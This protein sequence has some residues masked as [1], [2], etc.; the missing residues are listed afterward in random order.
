MLF[1]V[2]NEIDEFA[3][4]TF[5]GGLLLGLGKTSETRAAIARREPVIFQ[6]ECIADSCVVLCDVLVWNSR[7]NVYDLIEVKSSTSSSTRRD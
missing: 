4:Q 3:R 6:G 7:L 2:G 1:A 5:P